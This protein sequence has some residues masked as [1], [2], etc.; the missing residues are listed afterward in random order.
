MFKFSLDSLSQFILASVH[1]YTE[2]IYEIFAHQLHT[3]Y[4]GQLHMI[5]IGQLDKVK[6]H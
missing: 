4:T 2:D 5:Y 1:T 6:C 3:V